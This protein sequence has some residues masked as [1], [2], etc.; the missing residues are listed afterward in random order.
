MTGLTGMSEMTG[1]IEAIVPIDLARRPWRLLRRLRLQQIRATVSGLTLLVGHNDRGT[2][3]DAMLKR[4][5][6]REQVR[7]VS[8]AFYDG[9]VNNARLRNE[10]MRAVRAPWTLLLDADVLI[11]HE[12]IMRMH[13]ALDDKQPFC[14]APCLYLSARGSRILLK[15]YATQR[16][17]LARYWSF[18]RMPFLH[19]AIPSSVALFATV[20]FARV[21]GFDERFSGHGYED[22]DFLLRLALLH[23]LAP[24]TSALLCDRSTRA[25][26]LCTG[27]RAW[28][29]RLA[30]PLLLTESIPVHLWHATATDRYYEMR[31]AN[32]AY[33]FGKL[34]AIVGDKGVDEAIEEAAEANMP[35]PDTAFISFWM[36]LCRTHGLAAERYTILFEHRP[37]HV[38]RDRRLSAI[39]ATHW[40]RIFY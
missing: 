3:A 27:F 14:I 12:T 22:L 17:L 4:F 13:A 16:S 39:L 34:R 1:M 18:E 2:A 31:A 20:D 28:L 10:A 33:F 9:H 25:P 7:I 32:A 37:G 38:D 19:L 6:R 15:G 29:A 11:E 26:L 21:G 36:A 23:D 30:L 24:R 40:A 35:F 8:G 5:C